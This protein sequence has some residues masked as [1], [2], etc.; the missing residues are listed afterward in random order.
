M[1]QIHLLKTQRFYPLF[2]TQFLGA[3]N[4]NFLKNALVILITFKTSAILG[5]PSSQMVAVAGGIFILPFFLF[6]ATAGQLAD[7]REKSQLIRLIKIAEIA[8]MLLAALGF[9][10]EHFEFLLLVLF[11]MGLHSTFFGP[12][13][14]S[15]LPQHL[16]ENELVGG[17][18]LV[19]AGTFLAILLGTIA[20][21]ILIS[22]EHGP[23]LVSVGLICVAGLGWLT[24]LGV[25]EAKAV[26]PKLQ[27]QWNPIPPTLEIYRSTRKN[28][29][30]FLSILGIS[31]FWF[32]GGS[33]LSLFPPYCKDVLKT[34]ESVVTLF[35]ATFSI[36]IGVGSLLCERLSRKSL[37]LGLVPLGSIGITLFASDLYWTG[38]PSWIGN[39]IGTAAA[40]NAAQFL[41]Q[42]S[43]LRI[44]LDLLLMSIF[45]G[46]FIVPLYTLIQERA[47]VSY[48]SRII[49]SN[50][51]LNALFMVL[52][53]GVILVMMRLEL[54][55]PQMFLALAL[56]NAVAAIYIYTLLPEFLIRFIIWILANIMYRLKINGDD[57]IPKQGAAILVCNHVSFV[58]WMIISAGIKR[59]I[60]FIMDHGYAKSA[61]TRL[62]LK[63]G[64][65]I[66]IAP[67]KENPELL[68]A[69][70][71][72]AAQELRDGAL[73]C[74]FP[75][76]TITKDG[77]L[78]PF[79]SGVEKILA[80]TPVPVV[81]M[82]LRGLWGSFFSREG[83]RAIMK[84]PKRFWSRVELRI[85]EPLMAQAA[86]AD[87]LYERV[88]ALVNPDAE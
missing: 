85:G 35:L 49:A 18:A 71:T 63:Q 48:R 88:G 12:I 29:T 60:R 77:K 25:P 1:S 21:G 56:M 40:I 16:N 45:S 62:L 75:E 84:M 66:L 19:E 4:D 7:K 80:E 76:G 59:P 13:K 79:R 9:M 64:K 67:A 74:I 61:F 41:Q 31:W 34:D 38:I 78:N 72:Q 33:F 81:P 22:V 5:I 32:F 20:G 57:R 73:V 39:D 58:D 44:I 26:A 87:L 51:I 8:I 15:I 17:N 55:I 6:S 82:A 46:F 65:V 69:A 10:T 23:L 37:E 36:G 86:S 24:S 53:A 42:S 83:G 50:N 70:F 14:Y 54:T 3:F 68:K 43:G 2:W 52:S 47:D 28:R 11:L 27:V 30:V